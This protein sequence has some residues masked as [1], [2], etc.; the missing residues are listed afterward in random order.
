[1]KR[2]PVLKGFT[3]HISRLRVAMGCMA[4]RPNRLPSKMHCVS[5]SLTLHQYCKD[6][7][8]SRFGLT[9]LPSLC[10]TQ[11]T[12]QVSHHLYKLSVR[13]YPF[14]SETHSYH[15]FWG[16]IER[17]Y[18]HEVG[19]MWVRSMV[20][21]ISI[22]TSV[23]KAVSNRQI[24]IRI[25]IKTRPSTEG[26]L[27]KWLIQLP[28]ERELKLLRFQFPWLLWHCLTFLNINISFLTLNYVVLVSCQLPLSLSSS[29]PN[30]VV[31]VK[32]SSPLDKQL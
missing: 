15:E 27:R 25:N 1:M 19:S 31:L 4:S 28:S 17:F 9:L 3:G 11:G 29:F 5:S 2:I 16:I 30:P 14:S 13:I 6:T 21:T 22:P 8:P 32:L 10:P 20:C 23:S 18:W 7:P 12:H 26:R 24:I